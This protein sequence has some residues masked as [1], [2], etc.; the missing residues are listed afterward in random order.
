MKRLLVRPPCCVLA[1]SVTDQLM[2]DEMR[3]LKKRKRAAD[4]ARHTEP[5][6]QRTRLA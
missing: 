4:A 5:A 1:L 2:Q 6:P 3:P